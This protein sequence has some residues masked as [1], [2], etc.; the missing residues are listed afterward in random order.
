MICQ[1]YILYG[2]STPASVRP[3]IRLPLPP[4]MTFRSFILIY[5]VLF[6]AMPVIGQTS[7]VAW[8]DATREAKPWTRWWW[9]GSIGDEKTLSSEMEKYAAAGLGGLE[10]TC[11]YGVRGYEDRFVDF[12]SPAWVQKFQHTLAE[13]RRLGLG[14]D[15]SNGTGWP[16]GGPW[17]SETD[18]AHN[19]L[20]K[21][22]AIAPGGRL[23]EPV[24][25]IQ[26]PVLNFTR[27]RKITLAEL[28]QPI[29]A[30]PNLQ[31]LAID[32]VRFP[33]AVPLVSLMAYP[34]KGAPLDLTAKTDKEGKLDWS[35]PTDQGKWTL[36]ALFQ[37][38]HGKMV[39]RAAP[40]AEG[41]ALD[42][43]SSEA[44]GHYLAKFDEAFKG[45]DT[46]SL[47]AFFNDSYEVDD[48][49]G[50]SDFT[51]DFL[52]QFQNLRGYD[53]RQ[54]L[55][56]FFSPVETERSSRVLSDYRETVSD[57]LLEGFTKNWRKWAKARG[58]LVRNQAH[59]S[60]ANILDL[61]AASDIPEQEGSDIL[62][63][64]MASSVA[65]VTGKPL[66]S[67]EVAT[68]LNDHFLTTLA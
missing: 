62:G 20:H 6:A 5:A 46:R 15:L 40:G 28:K 44:I 65:H 3:P 25:C 14:I 61:Y 38:Q 16:F 13:G 54:H 29:T 37:G 39:E 64:K 55:P 17:L 26:E 43:L 24:A 12:L 30:N 9:P 2:S 58:T 32:Q 23:A 19:L 31:D 59:N 67:A 11:I 48:S 21:T 49:K 42:H 60:P 52:T 53:L 8:P 66:A 18:V 56:E 4:H 10:L 22:Y 68:W 34:E 7:P 33:R 50:E 47:R 45:C 35:A 36:Y 63:Y 1:P 57:L 27:P 41:Y 51:P